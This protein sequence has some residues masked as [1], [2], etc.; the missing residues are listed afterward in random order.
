MKDPD[1]PTLLFNSQ[2]FMP[3]V[4]F[5]VLLSRQNST[6]RANYKALLAFIK[7]SDG[8][9]WLWWSTDFTIHSDFY[10]FW[11]RDKRLLRRPVMRGLS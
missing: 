1:M 9:H 7:C 4:T 11:I 3:I 5:S 8:W 10:P 6:L 2:L